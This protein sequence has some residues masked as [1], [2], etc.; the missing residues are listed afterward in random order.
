MLVCMCT[1]M[2]LGIRERN[3]RVSATSCVNVSFHPSDVSEDETLIKFFNLIQPADLLMCR[4]SN[5]IWVNSINLIVEVLICAAIKK[6][7]R[8]GF[9]N[10][11]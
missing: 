8:I 2:A 11:S 6:K 3:V 7:N 5:F 1:L 9:E 4:F 10:D